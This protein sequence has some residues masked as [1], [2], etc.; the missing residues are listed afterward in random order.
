ML[1]DKMEKIYSGMAPDEIPWHLDTPPEILRHLVGTGRIPP[2]R[3]IELGCETGDYVMYLEEMGFDA[4]GVDFSKTAI[5]IARTSASER[6]MP[7]N[8]IVSDVLGDMTEVQNTFDFAFDW[9][10]LHHLFPQAR[11]TYIR[12]VHRLLRTDGTYLSVCFSDKDPDFGSTGKYRKTPLGTVLYFSSE[13]EIA[14][15][16][17]PL[18]KIDTMK[19][20]EIDGKVIPHRAI[21]MVARKR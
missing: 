15:L 16:V 8:F 19:T 2:C 11:D 13:D 10:L 5:G 9:E 6:G 14:V 1:K 12:N 17:E 4:T 18:F 7:G 3:A 20:V 21:C